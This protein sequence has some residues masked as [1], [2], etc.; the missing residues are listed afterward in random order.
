YVKGGIKMIYNYHSHTARCN[1][2]VGEDEEYVRCAIA[3]G[4]EEIGFSDHSPWPFKNGFVSGMRMGVDEI[5][6]Y[7]SSVRKLRKKYKDQINIKIGFECEYFREYIPWLRETAEK[8]ELDYLI[9]GHH[10]SPDEQY[11]VYNGFVTTP[12]EVEN[13][14]N[15]VLEA[16]DC[17]LFSYVAHPDLYMRMYPKFDSACEKAAREIIA[18]SNETGIPI[19]YNLLGI[20]HGKAAG[21]VGYPHPEFWKIAG[22]MNATAVIGIDAH[23]P[24]AYLDT[25]THHEAEQLLARLG[26]KLTDKIKMFR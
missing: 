21:K 22:E 23:D 6:D 8:Y 18:K 19:E 14:K 25:K 15:D 16:M 5:D 13:Y 26:V 4:Y 9:L 12:K 20:E 24:K 7:I 17:G 2:A 3:A 11:G 10:F 1:H